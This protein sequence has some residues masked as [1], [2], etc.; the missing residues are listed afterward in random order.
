MRIIR[1]RQRKTETEFSL[2]FDET[3]RPGCGFA[4]PCDQDGL[5]LDDDRGSPEGRESL[6]R[7]LAGEGVSEGRVER[8]DRSWIECAVGI[9]DSCGSRVGLHGFTNSCTGC[10][11]EYN[12]S[13]QRLAPR[14]QWGA[15]TG[16]TVAEILSVDADPESALEGGHR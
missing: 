10:P 5:V 16:E 2:V 3:D 1:Q 7:C 12:M 14:S 13:G 11:A 9:C 6:R 4:F 8:Y 15:E